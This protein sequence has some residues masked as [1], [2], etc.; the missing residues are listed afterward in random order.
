LLDRRRR[1]AGR[2]Q[3]LRRCTRRQGEPIGRATA[4]RWRAYRAEGTQVLNELLVAGD[5]AAAAA[6]R[7]GES[8]HHDVD[9]RRIHPQVLA[10]APAAGAQRA[11]AVRLIKVQIGAV[12]LLDGDDLGQAAD[13]AL[14]RVDALH[15]DQDLG[16]RPVRAR[17]PLRHG[18]A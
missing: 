11:D 3:C 7:L 8:A 12:L 2:V 5:V 14:H 17:L 1:H 13:L 10:H 18:G 4:Q 9:I 16:P 15:H 6:E